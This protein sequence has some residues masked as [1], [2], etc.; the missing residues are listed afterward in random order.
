MQSIHLAEK[1]SADGKSDE[2]IIR[3]DENMKRY[4]RQD[5]VRLVQEE[6]VEFIRLQFT[7]ILG[8]L[9]N[10]AITCGQ[11]EKALDNRYLFDASPIQGLGK[12][13]QMDL[14]LHPDYDTFE[15]F[16]W[17][18]QHGK[19]ARLLCDICYADGTP[20]E[21]DPRYILKKVIAQAAEMG[22]QLEAGPE[23]EFFL[24]HCDENGLPTTLTHEQAGYFDVSP[25][26]LGENARRDIVMMLEDMGFEIEASY[27]ESAPAQHEVDFRRDEALKTADNIMTFKLAVKSIAKR[28]GLH[29]TFMPKPKYG[30][31]GS[32]MH[33]NMAILKDGKNIFSQGADGRSP[34]REAL[35]FIGGI[36]AHIKGMT[37]IT[38]PLVNS[39]KRIVS[40]YEAPVYVTWSYGD[41][42]QMIRTVQDKDGSWRIEL[43]SPDSA[44]NPY[45]ALALCL[46]A[47]L[48][49][50]KK[51]LMPPE[52][53]DCELSALT[54][55]EKEEKGIEEIPATL[56]EALQE[57]KKDPLIKEVL[58]EYAYETYL[59]L[60]KQEWDEYKAQ[61]SEWELG[62][63]L[64][65]Y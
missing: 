40:G 58:G 37:A 19:V 63:Y 5:I 26:D 16:P 59:E 48:E 14:Y 42:R 23:C 33:L 52:S 62:Q 7:D 57:M 34:S 56:L 39:Y 46:S 65:R 21:A 32:G 22:Y 20:Y 29:A 35:Y 13:R 53:M 28:H 3:K 15:I 61:I 51:Q 6:D 30:V 49:G 31:D 17:R 27:H 10:I 12:K 9:K 2:I 38:N 41:R 36:M 50:M 64:N 54:R 1:R 4:T 25:L 44:A 45:L 43:R 18:P 11:L 60:K 55:R 47:G 24:F 8:T